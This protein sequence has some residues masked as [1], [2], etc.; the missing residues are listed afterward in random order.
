MTEIS[1][2]SSS[3]NTGFF[4]VFRENGCKLPSEQRTVGCLEVRYMMV[5]L[6][7]CG[8]SLVVPCPIRKLR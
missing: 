5:K 4:W 7:Y 3:E 6:A 2:L 1:C 8:E